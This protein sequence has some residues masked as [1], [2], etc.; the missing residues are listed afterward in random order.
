MLIVISDIPISSKLF[1]DC[2]LILAPRLQLGAHKWCR[3]GEVTIRNQVKP[4]EGE[5]RKITPA[6]LVGAGVPGKVPVTAQ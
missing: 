5:R 6:C 3:A 1:R 2:R 4:A